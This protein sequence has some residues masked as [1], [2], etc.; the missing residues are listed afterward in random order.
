MSNEFLSIPVEQI[1]NNYP[2]LDENGDVVRTKFS[3][4]LT[5]EEKLCFKC[6]LDDCKENS[7]KCL[8]NG[9]KILKKRA[10]NKNV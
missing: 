2:Q 10:E 6:P 1:Y 3:H 9:E 7:S 4:E 8:I 5:D